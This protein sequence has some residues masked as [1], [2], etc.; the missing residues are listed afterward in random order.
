MSLASAELSCA[1]P[2][3]GGFVVWVKEA[4]GN[5]IGGHNMYWVWLSYLFD[6]AVYPGLAGAYLEHLGHTTYAQ[7][8]LFATAIV[9]SLTITKLIGL[10]F[11]VRFSVILAICSLIPA[12]LYC[13]KGTTYLDSDS[14]VVDNGAGVDWAL[15]CS[16]SLW[17]YSGFL[18]LGTLAGQVKNPRHTM[19]VTVFSLLFLVVVINIYPLL[20]S[21]SLDSNYSDYEA[22]TF[23][24]LAASITGKWMEYFF[25]AGS[26][27]CLLGLYNSVIMTAD[28]SLAVLVSSHFPILSP[29]QNSDYSH[30]PFWRRFLFDISK[31]GVPRF[32][33]LIDAVIAGSLIWVN[34]ELLVEFNMLLLSLSTILFMYS[35]VWM[36]V[37]LP[38]M[39]RPYAV[40][41]GT[42]GA[43]LLASGP[44]IVSLVNVF[45]ALYDDPEVLGLPR[46]KII[47]LIIAVGIGLV[48][49]IMFKLLKRNTFSHFLPMHHNNGI[50]ASHRLISNLS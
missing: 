28:Y 41:G 48:V 12:I 39:Q 14:W 44:V 16:W 27:L 10:E 26:G 18:S 43:I 35:F 24:T 22:G 1:M 23:G 13:V 20:V 3:D 45:F 2:V 19:P 36:R 11:I 17:L 49:Q 29:I 47:M 9:V 5:V 4:C 37:S 15:L 34:Y 8:K 6:S 31:T 46:A 21:L 7:Q 50:Q 33:I 30:Y 38:L 25:L 40:P 32:Y 42:I